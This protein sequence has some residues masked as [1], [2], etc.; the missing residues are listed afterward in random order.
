MDWKNPRALVVLFLAFDGITKVIKERYVMAA[1]A[2]FGMSAHFIV[3][4]GTI[5][6][7][8]TAIYVIPQTSVLGVVL[9]TGYLGGAFETQF[10]A[11]NPPFETIFPILFA[12]VARL[13]LYLCGPRIR[14]ILP[15][16]K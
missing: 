16:R 1:S 14:A 3:T 6:L 11:G 13:G 5:L 7:I 2:Q 9:L 4:I 8:C 10:R 12:G 15:F